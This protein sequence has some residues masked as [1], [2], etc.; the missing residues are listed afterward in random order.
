MINISKY[1]KYSYL[2]MMGLAV[3]LL[4]SFIALWNSLLSGDVKHEGWVILFF[5]ITFLIAVFLFILAYK[6]SDAKT[7]ESFRMEAFEAGK[8]EVFQEIEKRNQAEK[9]DLKEDEKDIEKA[10]TSILSGI[11]GIRTLTGLC[12][13]I[14]SNLAKH[15]EFVQGIMYVK[16]P[17]GEQFNVTGE[18]ALTDRKPQ[19]F[20]NGDN[21]TGQVTVGKSPVVVFD[22]PEDYFM[23]SSG[24]GSSKPRFLVLVPIH[25][26]EE[27]IAVLELA[28]FKKPD[29]FTWKVLNKIASE[30]G[31]RLNKFVFA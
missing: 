29:E 16:E 20:K 1:R 27:C 3:S 19:P 7:L 17:K 18:Y 12:N 23:V 24:L 10:I 2:G 26:K 30:L 14:L 13:K 9:K 11:Q 28:A 5:L 4:L 6:L 22:I 25:L 21:L 15:M 8:N 31:N